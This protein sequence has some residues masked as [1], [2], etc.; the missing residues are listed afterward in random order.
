MSLTEIGIV[1]VNGKR[2]GWLVCLVVA[3]AENPS[4][5]KSATNWSKANILVLLALKSITDV[6][7]KI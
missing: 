5:T 2:G 6:G 3:I 4:K 1:I 7:R